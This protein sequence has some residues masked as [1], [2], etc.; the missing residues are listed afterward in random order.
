MDP[1]HGPIHIDDQIESI[2]PLYKPPTITHSLNAALYSSKLNVLLIFVPLGFLAHFLEWN[3]ATIF[4]LNFLGLI[5]LANLLGFVTEDIANRCGQAVGGLLNATFGNAEELIIAVLALMRGEIRIVQ[6]SMLGSIISNLLLVLG[7]CFIAGGYKHKEQDFNKKAAQT[8]SGLLAIACIGLVIPAAFHFE[9]SYQDDNAN[10]DN[11]QHD[12]DLNLSRGIALVLL[13]IYVLFLYFQLKTHAYLY[14]EEESEDPELSFGASIFL[15]SFITIIITF[16]SDFLIDSIEGIVDLGLNKTFV[17]LI[18]LPIV[19]NAA[20]HA[21][22]IKVAMKNKMD[23]A[24]S[25]AVG[26]ST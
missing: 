17:G 22:A 11:L 20:E 16:S 26:S 18:L 1:T 23:L 9:G 12:Q 14:R 5:P 6:A 13:V 21:S 4:I 25:I 8:N 10:R 3:S 15:L 7:S 2:E 19:G 24:I